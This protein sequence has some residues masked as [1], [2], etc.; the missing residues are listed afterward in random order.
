MTERLYY[1][2]QYIKEFEAEVVSCTE[3]K[4]G[5]EV[6][7]DKTAFFPEGGGQPG[8]R[9]FIGEAKVIDTVEKDD[10]IIH[11]CDAAVSGRVNCTLD[12]DL[13]FSNM[14]QH[15]GEHVFSGV[16]HSMLGYDNVGFHMGESCMTVDFNG[17]VTADQLAE[18]ER[19][20][21]EAVYR[22]IPVESIYPT[23]EELENYDY[24]SKKEIKGQVRL[25]KIGDVDLCACCGTHVAMTGEIGPIKAVSMM[26]YKSGVRITLQ[27]GRKAFADYCEKN[28]SV[29]AIS[30]LLCAKTE[31]V[32]EAVEKLQMRLKDADF[33]YQALKKELF[34]EKIKA[35]SGERYCMFDDG[36]SAD[37][38]RILADMLADK[39]G[40]AAVFSGNDDEGYKYAVVSRENDV[41]EIGKAINASLNGRGGGKPNMIQ[42]SVVSKRSTVEEFWNNL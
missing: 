36:A 1:K 26:N 5:F 37:D 12:F 41:R 2:D 14:Q 17:V 8:D 23:A 11:I 21:N 25:T 32:A 34:A 15:S 35:V 30:A 3:G 9:G 33:R 19:L 18:I 10:E 4:N 28:A 29:Y 40:I 22:N 7:L 16:L 20:S 39:V 24:R 31:E 27:V 13:R 6:I 38:A 42:G